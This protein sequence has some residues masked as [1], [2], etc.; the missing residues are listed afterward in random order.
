MKF[1]KRVLVLVS[2][3][4]L[5]S[6]GLS[7]CGETNSANQ[8]SGQT[9]GTIQ[10]IKDSGVVR[11]GVFSDKAPFG[12]VDSTGEYQGYDVE[13]ARRIGQDLG[14]DVEFVPVDA[15][16][17]V[18]VLQSNKVDIVLANFTVTDERAQKVDFALPYMNVAL[19]LVS[20]QLTPLSSL[21][22]A[23]TSSLPLIVVKGTTADTFLE[24]SYPNLE[25][26]KFEQY[27]DAQNA[28]IDGR[29]SGW[30]TDNTE[31]IAFAKNNQGFVVPETVANLGDADKIAPAV[32]K[33]KAELLQWINEEIHNLATE[34]FF[35]RDY[36]K[37]LAGT[38]GTE[39]EETLVLEGGAP[40]GE[41]LYE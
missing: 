41:G 29:G 13:F 26:T 31:A 25:V 16:A 37:T 17:R 19:G 4:A 15:A 18:S 14:V 6:V 2:V 35:H 1:L 39:Y 7:S 27:N 34:S 21:G 36:E 8:N 9:K 38:Y 33:G 20:P 23:Q 32:A 24:K 10:T 22:D 40:L 12:Y 5:A 30:L 11:I 3:V 28:L